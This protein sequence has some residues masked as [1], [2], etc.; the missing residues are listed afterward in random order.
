MKTR[1]EYPLFPSPSASILAGN[2]VLISTRF[3]DCLA[4]YSQDWMALMAETAVCKR[5]GSP[6][7]ARLDL[8]WNEKQAR[9][10]LILKICDLGL[11]SLNC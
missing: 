3:P 4:N 6:A 2:P 7:S 1:S 11:C 8:D 9:I 10:W 5:S